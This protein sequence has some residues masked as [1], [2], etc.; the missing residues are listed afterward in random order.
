MTQ[1][2]EP[3]DTSDR[4][5]GVALILNILLGVFGGHRFYAGKPLSGVLMAVTFGGLGLWWLYDLIL[6]ASG[7]FRDGDERLIWRWWQ[8][9]AATL[10]G[11]THRQLEMVFDELD[12]L[13][14]EMTEVN[15]RIDFVERVLTKARDQHALPAGD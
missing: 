12:A 7:S 3:T 5:R 2:I 10:P 6:I 14:G 9:S 11:A 13:R 1:P 4:L 15:E 8:T